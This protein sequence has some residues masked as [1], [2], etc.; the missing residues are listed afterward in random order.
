MQNLSI[1]VRTITLFAL[2][3]VTGY[4][5]LL[6]LAPFINSILWAIAIAMFVAPL[7]KWINQK[8]KYRNLA[9]LI[10]VV[11]TVGVVIVPAI[12]LISQTISEMLSIF[13]QLRESDQAVQVVEWFR[14][15]MFATWLN[16][17]FGISPDSVQQ[18]IF[19][20]LGKI[21]NTALN[22]V[23]SVISNSVSFTVDLIFTIFTLFFLLR[24]GEQ[25]RSWILR[26]LPMTGERKKILVRRIQD[27][28]DA[29]FKGSL[30]VGI[31]QGLLAGGM[32]L[33]LGV[34]GTFFWTIVMIVLSFLPIIGAF[35]V[36]A[37]VAFWFLLTGH[38][39]KGIILTIWGVFV[40]GLTDNFLRPLVV[41]QQTKI[42][43]GIV[44]F[45]TLGGV[46]L[47][48]PIGLMIGPIMFSCFIVVV[49]FL[50]IDGNQKSAKNSLNN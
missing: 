44:F 11:V 18:T 4:F 22:T 17:K 35:L 27:V 47:F 28:I 48:G 12:I 50:F 16:A 37:P 32:F 25:L 31:A 14:S 5:L 38:I 9:A 42:H 30:I 43:T 1:N 21:A 29:T 24:D 2:L 26:A 23:Q 49:E 36:W 19:D 8:I 10:G 40:V 39:A 45:A 46:A 34:P 15:G 6:I 13:K 3:V 7:Q 41:S 20:T 33:V